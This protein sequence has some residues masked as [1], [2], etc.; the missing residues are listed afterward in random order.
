MP[1][2]D[3]DRA[4]GLIEGFYEAAA[5]PELWRGLLA[6]M[7]GALGAEGCVLVP[8]PASP[9]Q[10]VC[11]ESMDELCAACLQQG[12]HDKNIRMKRG[13]EALKTRNGVVTE[14]MLFT[15]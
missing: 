3:E 2:F 15:S 5:R 7:A 8:G 14:S 13:I 6:Q 11:S 1:K 12:W 4:A 10:P 9:I